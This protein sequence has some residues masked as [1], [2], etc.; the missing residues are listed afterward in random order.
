MGLVKAVVGSV[1]G[2]VLSETWKDYFVC[3]SMDNDVL[4]CKGVKRGGG[5]SGE[6]IT[7][8]S[9]IVVNEG[10]CA[11]IVENGNI[12]EVAAEPGNYTFDSSLSP[13]VFDGGWKGIKDTFKDM[14]GRFTFGG[15][16]NK[17]QRVYYVNT[18]EIM[19]NRFGTSTP[20]PFRVLISEDTGVC[21]DVSLRCNGEY[22][23]QIVNPLTFYT[24]VCGNAR[25]YFTKEDLGSIMKSE[26][27]DA[28]M[29][30]VG[31]LSKLG[32]RYSELPLHASEL[33][34]AMAEKLNPKWEESRGIHFI[35]VAI[36]SV[37]IPEEDAEK[38]KNVQFSAVNK[39]PS[40]ANATIITATADALRDAAKNEGGA[41][42]GLMNMNMVSNAASGLI[43]K[44]DNNGPTYSGGGYCPF[45]GAG[46]P[47]G[48]KF[49]PA[50]GKQLAQ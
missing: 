15:E 17:S 12:L 3:D 38:L 42:I 34:D 18:K 19:G 25:D 2:G 10:Q 29:P 16:T 41:A 49:C 50:C 45:C 40:M 33:K 14:L 28:L 4:V 35:S 20:I 46:L 48:A 8:G 39:D 21:V 47:A 9:G 44:T 5:G 11:L 27:L 1:V 32:F 36:A 24:K 23:F 6:I 43:Q 22:S 37:T 26:M 30:A 13:S 31:E 7:N